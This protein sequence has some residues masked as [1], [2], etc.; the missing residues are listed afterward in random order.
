MKICPKCKENKPDSMFHRSARAKNGLQSRC[1]E[2]HK[3]YVKENWTQLRAYQYSWREKNP[4]KYKEIQQ[5]A[6]PQK[7]AYGLKYRQENKAIF[8]ARVAAWAAKNYDH[9][10]MTNKQWR[11]ENAEHNKEVF[12]K[13]SIANRDKECAK[14]ARH[15]AAKMKACPSWAN[16]Q[17][18]G[19]IYA[20]A[21]RISRET[22]IKHH[23]DHI[24]PLQSKWLC[25]LHVPLNLRVIPAS[26]NMSKSNRHW[27][28]SDS[29]KEAA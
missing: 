6:A 24:Y 17:E 14:A 18:I 1:I 15:R 16:L 25:G 21:Q 5:R 19:L 2:C 26:D 23:V 27:P 4:E 7:K 29:I 28:G 12:R 11:I 10:R 3:K 22:G 9:K 20:E 13:W 8:N